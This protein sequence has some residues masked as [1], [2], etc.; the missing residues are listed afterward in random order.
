M[1][2]HF[3]SALREQTLVQLAHWQD[4]NPPAADQERTDLDGTQP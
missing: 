2:N 3:Y 4:V 1:S